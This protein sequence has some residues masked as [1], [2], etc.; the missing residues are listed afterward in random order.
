[1]HL[2][3]YPHLWNSPDPYQNGYVPSSH[4]FYSWNQGIS[5]TAYSIKECIVK[6]EVAIP[7]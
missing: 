5:G 7:I 2:L 4:P 6:R 3:S 1:M